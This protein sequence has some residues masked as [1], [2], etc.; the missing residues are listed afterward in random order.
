MSQI[1]EIKK[2]TERGSGGGTSM[3]LTSKGAGTYWSVSAQEVDASLHGLLL[4]FQQARLSDNI[5]GSS[6]VIT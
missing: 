3:E 1:L 4:G 2:D 6:A 5:I